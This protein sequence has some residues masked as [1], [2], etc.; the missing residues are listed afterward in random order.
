LRW[1]LATSSYSRKLLADVE[2]A[3]LDL[4]LRVLDGARHHAR[5]DRLAFGDLER[6]HDRLQPLAGEDLEQRILEREE[7]REE[8]GSPLPARPA[9][10]LVVDTA[11]FM[12]LRSR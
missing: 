11:G 12:P 2:V 8:P 6:A 4:A 10:Q 7:K 3:G 5:L 1:S 9:P